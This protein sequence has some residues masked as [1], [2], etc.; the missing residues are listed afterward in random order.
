MKTFKEKEHVAIPNAHY[1]HTVYTV[2]KTHDNGTVDL[3]DE[4]GRGYY[5]VR[6][7][8]LEKAKIH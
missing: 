3:V 6:T 7:N 4:F 5:G 8:L 2:I 1:A